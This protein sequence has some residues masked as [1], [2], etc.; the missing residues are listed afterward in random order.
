MKT[1]PLSLTQETLEKL[2]Q[3]GTCLTFNPIGPTYGRSIMERQR[4][5]KLKHNVKD[6]WI[7]Q[8]LNTLPLEHYNVPFHFFS[9]GVLIH[10]FNP[11]KDYSY[12]LEKIK[13]A[14]SLHG[15]KIKKIYGPQVQFDIFGY[16]EFLQKI[17]KYADIQY[18]PEQNLEIM[19]LPDK[20]SFLKKCFDKN[21]ILLT[22]S[23]FEQIAPTYRKFLALFED[24]SFFVSKDYKGGNSINDPETTYDFS[25]KYNQYVYFKRKYVPQDYLEAL[26]EKAKTFDWYISENEALKNLPPQENL[27]DEEK[28]KMQDYIKTLLENRK[29]IS[30]TLPPSTA[31]YIGHIAPHHDWYVLFNDGKLILSKDRHE[32]ENKTQ[33]QTLQLSY[34]DIKFDIEYVPEHYIAA[35]YEEVSKIQKTAKDI[36]LEI[37][38]QKARA[39][40]KLLQ[41]PHHEA[42]E[43]SAQMVGFKSWKDALSMNER[44]ARY[45]IERENEKKKYALEQGKD[46]LQREYNIYLK[47]K[48][49]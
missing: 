11:T 38:K 27:T 14:L 7:I 21:N 26:Y 10:R 43:L 34:P 32:V 5:Y 31:P 16:S 41:I 39:L 15:Y 6:V 35:I 24:G 49:Q 33:I 1:L 2:F 29:C 45:A 40:K 42:L 22:A 44:N 17:S 20:D 37:L 46:P 36:Y 28:F 8:K 12:M 13:K 48:A 47:T 4:E 18:P 30:V 19:P 25:V 3:D 23:K 9:N